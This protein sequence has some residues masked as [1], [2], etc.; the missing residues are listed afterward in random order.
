MPSAIIEFAATIDSISQRSAA[1]DFTTQ[2]LESLDKGEPVS[3][4]V[5]GRPCVLVPRSL[6][7]QLREAID[8]WDPSTTRRQM[9]KIM[10]DDWDDPAM[11]AY[12]E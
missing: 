6:Y 2:Q 5:E 4:S 11:S 3:I 7:D 10:A 9:A 8:D 1:V 12:D